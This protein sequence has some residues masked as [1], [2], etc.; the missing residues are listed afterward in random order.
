MVHIMSD[1]VQPLKD[2]DKL[3]FGKHKGKYLIE[4]PASWL[5][6]YRDNVKFGKDLALLAYIEE[7]LDVLLQER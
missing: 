1:K 4:V 2:T 5:L 3:T 7:N 6:W